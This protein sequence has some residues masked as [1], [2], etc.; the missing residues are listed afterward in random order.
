MKSLFLVAILAAACGGKQPEP[1]PVANTA[2]ATLAE[3]AADPEPVATDESTAD[4]DRAE[5]Q[6][7]MQKTEDAP[8][9]EPPPPTYKKVRTMKVGK[10][11][12]K[13]PTCGK[14][15]DAS[16][17]AMKLMVYWKDLMCACPD[18]TCGEQVFTDMT[19]WAQEVAKTLDQTAKPSEADTKKMEE[20]GKELG[21]CTADVIMTDPNAT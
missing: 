10:K 17:C 6:Y 14:K 12:G 20:V 19:A 4:R 11:P 21:E 18:K 16:K 15:E 8:V 1:A 5:G 7:K 9:E 3:P 2:P 13:K